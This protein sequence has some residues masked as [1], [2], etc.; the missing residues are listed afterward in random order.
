M[1]DAYTDRTGSD[2]ATTPETSIRRAVAEDLPAV[3]NVLDGSLLDCPAASVRERIGAGTVLVAIEGERVRGALVLSGTDGP[4][5]E[6]EAIAVRRR[7]RGQGIGTALIERTRC[8]T[9]LVAEFDERVRP[10]YESL[11]FRIRSIDDGRYRGRLSR[12]LPREIDR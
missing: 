12:L 4:E 10:F 2:D 11:G 8:R 6:I 7:Y 9:T 5:S 3:M 1:N